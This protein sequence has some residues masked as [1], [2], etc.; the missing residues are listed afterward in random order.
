[1]ITRRLGWL[2]SLLLLT[3]TVLAQEFVYV[4]SNVGQVLRQN[5][6]YGYSVSAQGNLKALTGS[7]YLTKATGVYSAN[8]LLAP[9]FF[10]LAVLLRERPDLEQDYLLFSGWGLIMG[11]LMAWFGPWSTHKLPLY[12]PV[13]AAALVSRYIVTTSAGLKSTRSALPWIIETLLSRPS[14]RMRSFA[15]LHRSGEISTPT[16]LAP[17]C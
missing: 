17:N 12:G 4:E 3:G 16:P 6:V 7:P 10:L 2:V 13:M 11:A 5:S 14:E 1:M 15:L 9:G 8:P